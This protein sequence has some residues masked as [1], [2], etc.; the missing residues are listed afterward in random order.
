[1]RKESRKQEVKKLIST[2]KISSQEELV[3]LLNGLGYETTQAT[4]SRD[5]KEIGVARISD[6]EKGHIYVLPQDIGMMDKIGSKFNLPGESITFIEF[7]YNFGIIKTYPG[8]AS[9]VA[10]FIDS[11][12]VDEIAGT[13]AGDDTILVIPREPATKKELKAALSK[14]FPNNKI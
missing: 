5:L 4:L 13:I 11:S 1:M 7:S 3:E 9:S 6:N 2:R 10:I 12:K 14:L 8:F